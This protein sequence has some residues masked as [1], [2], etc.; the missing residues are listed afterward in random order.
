M[1][2][3]TDRRPRELQRVRGAAQRHLRLRWR[4]QC[5]CD[6]TGRHNKTI[7]REAPPY[8][9]LPA[10]GPST[11]VPV[12]PRVQQVYEFWKPSRCVK[13]TPLRQVSGW[14]FESVTAIACD[15]CSGS[16]QWLAHRRQQDGDTAHRAHRRVVRRLHRW[17]E[18][19]QPP[20]RRGHELGLGGRPRRLLVLD[21]DPSAHGAPLGTDGCAWRVVEETYRNASCVDGLVD[22]TVE[23][24]GTASSRRARNRRG[25]RL[26]ELLQEYVARRRRLQPDGDAA[27][28]IVEKWSAGFG[29][30]AAPSSSPRSAG[31]QCGWW[32]CGARGRGVIT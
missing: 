17:E 21:A 19:L 20:R 28:Q 4:V 32:W 22:A 15:A 30:G 12:P 18:A 1:R 24:Y 27:K 3:T 25:D 5:F 16:V 6:G 29:D 14:S 11:W 26:L 7:G 10:P 31:R 8:A 23:A 2:P 13:G 9:G